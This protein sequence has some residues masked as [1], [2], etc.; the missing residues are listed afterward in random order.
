MRLILRLAMMGPE[1]ELI[2]DFKWNWV[3]TG[4]KLLTLTLLTIVFA[5]IIDVLVIAVVASVK[6]H[7]RSPHAVQFDQF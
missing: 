6:T 3:S 5:V 7:C 1:E 2:E 4:I